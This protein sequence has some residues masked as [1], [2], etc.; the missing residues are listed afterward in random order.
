M[1]ATDYKK[2]VLREMHAKMSITNTGQL[3][4]GYDQS[5]VFDHTVDHLALVAQTQIIAGGEVK[6]TDACFTMYESG[7][8]NCK[9]I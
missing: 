2:K 8:K 7:L 1:L 6:D 9:T 3:R 4:N 5:K